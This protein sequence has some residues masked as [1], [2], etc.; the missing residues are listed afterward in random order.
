MA[1]TMTLRFYR[2]ASAVSLASRLSTRCISFV[3]MVLPNS[4]RP[5]VNCFVRTSLTNRATAH[6]INI[7][8]IKSF[9]LALRTAINTSVRRQLPSRR[10]FSDAFKRYYGRSG[11]FL[12]LAVSYCS[13]SRSRWG[14]GTEP[15]DRGRKKQ[16]DK[17]NENAGSVGSAESREGRRRRGLYSRAKAAK[18]TRWPPE[19]VRHRQ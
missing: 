19:E 4:L 18:R 11:I 1:M 6:T 9:M 3:Q 14:P 2:I 16:C 8:C 17:I 15:R 13:L 7:P 5:A 12:P 10:K